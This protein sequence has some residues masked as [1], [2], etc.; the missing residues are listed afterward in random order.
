MLVR[1]SYKKK[2][3]FF[4]FLFFKSHFG[5]LII[6]YILGWLLREIIKIDMEK[7]L[8]W[9][10]IL[11]LI[12]FREKL[13]SLLILILSINLNENFVYWTSGTGFTIPFLDE[14]WQSRFII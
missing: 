3:D 11:I 8:C 10:S 2:M 7:K 9:L 4:I 14:D 13:C 5:Q 12:Q 1:S 6:L